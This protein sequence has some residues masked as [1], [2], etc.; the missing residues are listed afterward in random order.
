[1]PQR[2]SETKKKPNNGANLGFEAI[3]NPSS[4]S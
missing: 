1:M 2:K 4:I 3:S